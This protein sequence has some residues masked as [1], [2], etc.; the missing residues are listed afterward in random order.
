[1]RSLWGTMRAIRI[2]M[3]SLACLTGAVWGALPGRSVLAVEVRIE[4]ERFIYDREKNTIA[5]ENGR[6]RAGGLTFFASRMELDTKARVAH[7]KGPV[8]F[9]SGHLRRRAV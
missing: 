2:G 7:S 5:Y 4:A 9:Q 6:L 1:M 3:L 8:R